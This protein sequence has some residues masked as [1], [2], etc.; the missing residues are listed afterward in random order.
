M[1]L[2]DTTDLRS[3]MHVS[4]RHA[5][6][7]YAHDRRRAR[8]ATVVGGANACWLD[9]SEAPGGR[10]EEC[11]QSQ[12]G[13]VRREPLG[14][15]VSS[16]PHQCRSIT[17]R[18]IGEG[19]VKARTAVHEQARRDRGRAAAILVVGCPEAAFCAR[20]AAHDDTSTP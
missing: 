4:R 14:R 3:R 10:S 1:L 7:R 18:W 15:E 5:A 19:A 2:E 17:P 11:G 8:A 16:A 6:T 12:L 9:A 20:R 13:P